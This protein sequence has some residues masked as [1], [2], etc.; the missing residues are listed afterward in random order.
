LKLTKAR[1]KS[2]PRVTAYATAKCVLRTN[3][4]YQTEQTNYLSSYRFH[5]L[6]KFFKARQEAYRTDARQIDDVLYTPYAYDES[7]EPA[8]SSEPQATNSEA[9][10]DLLGVPELMNGGDENQAPKRRKRSKF[11]TRP[12][13]A[14]VFIFK[15]GTVV[16]WGMTEA[17]EKRFLSS[18]W[19]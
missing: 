10:G 18:M 15:Y 2:L 11:D 8:P 13:L 17:Q 3:V 6:I 16:I 4:C 14:E 12:T 9:T 7:G 19:V 1:A 5:E